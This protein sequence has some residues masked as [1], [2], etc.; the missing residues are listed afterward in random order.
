MTVGVPPNRSS[1]QTRV[2]LNELRSA[3]RPLL[4]LP[5][6]DGDTYARA[7]AA[8]E[9]RSTQRRQLTHWLLDTLAPRCAQGDPVSILSVGAGDGTVDGVVAAALT[10]SDPARR[11]TYVGLDPHAAS[12]SAF[13]ER[14]TRLGR[15][16]LAVSTITASFDELTP[17]DLYDVIIFAH[18]LYYVPDV[19]VALELARR[20]LAPDGEILVLQAPQAGLNELAA[21]LAPPSSVGHQ[22][23][24]AETTHSAI[25]TS[26]LAAGESF[27]VGAL[28]LHICLDDADPLG[29]SILDFLVQTRLPEALRP[30]TVAVLRSLAIEPDGLLVD[31]PLRAWRLTE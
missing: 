31:H 15:P 10:A 4:P 3:A 12:G 22:Q 27:I 16:R 26:G 18:S 5:A 19:A 9:E 13:R 6:I 21:T 29:R 11:V 7:H 25:V 30:P 8:F 24:W 17:S 23:W 2:A 28:D 20:M 1:A 14:L